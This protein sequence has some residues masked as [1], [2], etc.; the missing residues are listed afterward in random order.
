M[1]P[2]RTARV[3]RLF[4]AL[5]EAATGPALSAIE[6]LTLELRETRSDG[7][8]L[9]AAWDAFLGLLERRGFFVSTPDQV[10]TSLDEIRDVGPGF[11]LYELA[12][13]M[14]GYDSAAVDCLGLRESRL[15]PRLTRFARPCSCGRHPPRR[16]KEKGR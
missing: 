9:Q 6:Q 7:E 15:F 5:E 12:A 4:G 13:G 16:R 8:G 11:D 1:T 10:A 2:D 3:R 14:A